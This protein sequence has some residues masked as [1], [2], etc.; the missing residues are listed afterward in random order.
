MPASRDVDVQA[1]V[2]E[3]PFS[4]FQWVVLSDLVPDPTT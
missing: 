3:H 1:F 2:N 4:G